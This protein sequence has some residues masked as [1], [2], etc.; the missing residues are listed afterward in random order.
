MVVTK[1]LANNNVMV[2]LN[3][4]LVVFIELRSEP[5]LMSLLLKTSRGYM[6]DDVYLKKRTNGYY[7]SLVYNIFLCL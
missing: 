1:E 6:A 4:L 5:H 2:L 7:F 3:K